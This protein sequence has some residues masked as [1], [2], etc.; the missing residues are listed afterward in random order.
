MAI[1]SKKPKAEV[2]KTE[3]KKA[4]VVKAVKEK[5]VKAPKAEKV[6]AVKKNLA[7]MNDSLISVIIRPRI[8][9]KATNA[10]E[11]GTYLFD[12]ALT[13]TKHSVAKAVEALYKVSPV[14]VNIVRTPAQTTYR[15]GKK[16]ST[17]ITK[18]AYVFLK[19][20]EKIEFV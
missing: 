14:K 9:E 5:A 2:A 3:A 16:G 18:K 17:G 7:A 10:A 4:P 8:T 1:F 15:R 19:K 12:V 13:A 6:V 20:G 11:N